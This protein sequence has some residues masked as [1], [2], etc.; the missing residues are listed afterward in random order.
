MQSKLMEIEMIKQQL[1]QLDQQRMQV[2]ARLM[3]SDA[4]LKTLKDLETGTGIVETFVP[5]GGGIFSKATFP[6]TRQVLVN[7]GQDIAV[8]KTVAEA[9]TIIEQTIAG[10]EKMFTDLDSHIMMLQ[11]HAELI[12]YSIEAASASKR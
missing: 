3:D 2:N 12:Y 9:K 10:Y 1:T 4:A 6:E 5:F 8:E 7:V 11:K